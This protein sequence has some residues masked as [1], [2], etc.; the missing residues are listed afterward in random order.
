MNETL[1]QNYN[2]KVTDKDTVWLLGDLGFSTFSDMYPL[3]KRLNG[4][5]Q[6]ILG[7]HDQRH[8]WNYMRSE[9]FESVAD[10]K[11]IKVEKQKISLFHY[12]I[13]NWASAHYGSWHLH[14]HCHGKIDG[15]NKELIEVQR[16]R[17]DVGV[18]GNNYTPVSFD[19]VQEIFSRGAS[20][21]GPGQ[22]S[23]S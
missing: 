18:D 4:H 17:Y 15:V 7:N 13:Y 14:A 16:Y 6:L 9:L 5:K 8:R 22:E 2:Q 10:Y 21:T 1:I 3:I 19:E 12:P 20:D 11:E 23:T